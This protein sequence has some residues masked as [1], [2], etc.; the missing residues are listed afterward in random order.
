MPRS[1]QPGPG[2]WLWVYLL[3]LVRLAGG[4]TD[5]GVRLH[6]GIAA[7]DLARSQSSVQR[8]EDFAALYRTYFPRLVMVVQARLHDRA[9][10]EDIAQE[11]LAR[12]FSRRD[13]LDHDRPLWPWLKTV[14]VN[15]CVDHVRKRSREVLSDVEKDEASLAL[16]V[17][18]TDLLA[19]AM[20]EL[21]NRQRVAM[22]LRYL[23]DWDNA[24]VASFLGLTKTG[25]EQLLHRA[26]RKLQFHYRK[27]S[28]DV[29]GMALVPVQ[30]ARSLL[31]RARRH[32][33]AVDPLGHAALSVPQIANVVAAAVVAWSVAPAAGVPSP[34]LQDRHLKAADTQL[35]ERSTAGR[36]ARPSSGSSR[37]ASS[38]EGAAGSGSAASGG[39]GIAAAGVDRPDTVDRAYD[40]ATDPNGNVRQPEDAHL[41]SLAPSPNYDSDRTIF[42]TGTV[43]CRL[44]SCE[45]VLFRSRN[46]GRTWK[47]LPA[48]NLL[49]DSVAVPAGFGT[50]H[51]RI[52]AMGPGG[53]Q[54]STDG[55]RSFA[56]AA[57]SD[58]P[59]AVGSMAVSPAF[60]AGDPSI[61]IGSQNLMHYDDAKRVITPAPYTS[62]P[63]PLEPA[64]SPGYPGD[65][66]VIVGAMKPVGPGLVSAVYRCTDVVCEDS[67][68]GPYGMVPKV[69]LA[70]DFA[71][72]DAMAA[73][74]TDR[75]FVS[76]DGAASFVEVGLPRGSTLW[77]VAV[78]RGAA[79]IFVAVHPTSGKG[80][81]GIFVS[82][83]LGDSWTKLRSP[84][85]ARGVERLSMTGSSLVA[86]LA[87]TGVACSSDGGRTWARRCR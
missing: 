34:G 37:S 77:D 31:K 30:A 81:A 56:G 1:G 69:R 59:Y 83:D 48:T 45:R 14:A 64:Y 2:R 41:L 13:E 6:M 42:A 25:F 74:L 71:S 32:A 20:S 47:R 21:P 16:D 33:A 72:S 58:A 66:R 70:P 57:L 80:P 38:P 61:L 43:H 4:G 26:R 8:D 3:A 85:L 73:F 78:A 17:E 11:A 52:F 9:L 67:F 23:D 35:H 87:G 27:L 53:L 84:L 49:G 29:L 46:A 5:L 50:V 40:D 82:S 62:L 24:Q 22:S 55:G 44:P 76:R 86:G 68:L 51:E 28:Q 54:V 12:A 63:G 79:Q 60:A 10:A 65:A 39:A 75:L 15:L 19:R 36:A 18:E 7:Q